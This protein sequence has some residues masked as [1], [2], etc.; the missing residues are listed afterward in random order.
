MAT[1]LA[2]RARQLHL[3][4][5][6][7]LHSLSEGEAH[8]FWNYSNKCTVFVLPQRYGGER[9][10]ISVPQDAIDAL[11]TN[12]PTTC[13]EAFQWVD[14]EFAQ[15]AEQVYDELRSPPITLTNVWDV[16]QLMEPLI[17]NLV[18]E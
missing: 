10:C 16:F 17:R 18:H 5:E 3:L 4:L 7:S 15:S 1:S 13:K 8:A 14:M 9:V 12:I 2:E 6:L 11:Q